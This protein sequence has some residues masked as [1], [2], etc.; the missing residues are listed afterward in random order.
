MSDLTKL[1]EINF[2]FVPEDF[3]DDC[4]YELVKTM[5]VENN[6]VQ[7]NLYC[8]TLNGNDFDKYKKIMILFIYSVCFQ[9]QYPMSVLMQLLLNYGFSKDKLHKVAKEIT[10]NRAIIRVIVDEMVKLSPPKEK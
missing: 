5:A 1:D 4:F 2:E 10:N 9:L 7:F 8:S 3:N 6:D